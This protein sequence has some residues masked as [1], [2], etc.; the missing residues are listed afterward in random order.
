MK[1]VRFGNLPPLETLVAFESAAEHES[2][3]RAG[4]ELFLTASAIAYHVKKL[5]S[6]LGIELFSRHGKGV[7]LT[8]KGQ[9]FLS[10]IRQSLN[11]IERDV[12]QV[13][14]KRSKPV[15]LA[16]Q[17]AVAQLWLHKRLGEYQHQFPEHDIEITAVSTVSG[18]P[19]N[20][21]LALGYF[22]HDPGGAW[23]KLWPEYLLPVSARGFN[24]D[25]PT[26]YQDMN[27]HDDW[28]YWRDTFPD[29]SA[30]TRRAS[31][32]TLLLQ[33][34]LDGQG[35]MV[36]RLSLLKPYLDSGVLV[37]WPDSTLSEVESGGYYLYC[38]PSCRDHAVATHFFEWLTT[39]CVA[40]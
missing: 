18:Q 35:V 11:S 25:S 28:R 38:A 14:S 39:T 26:F 15:K 33:S 3:A 20:T 16:T 31:L 22:L 13:R 30:K 2:F 9:E 10:L 23:I 21:D 37:P 5:E 1:S 24:E 36:G 8:P 27:W 34:V 40:R 12:E 4:E 7:S 29:I 6:N 19:E 32:Y 17:H